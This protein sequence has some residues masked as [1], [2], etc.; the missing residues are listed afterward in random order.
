M[1]DVR[2]L[3]LDAPGLIALA[4]LGLLDAARRVMGE[5]LVPVGVMAEA[6]DGDRPGASEVSAAHA[7]RRL[8]L[9]AAIDE[10]SIGLGP[11]ESEAIAHAVVLGRPAL[12]DDM[13]ARRVARRRGVTVVGTLAVLARLHEAGELPELGGALD[14]LERIGFRM[15]P[16]L[17][18]WAIRH[19]S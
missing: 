7:S 17:R 14:E 4:R 16:D 15:T 19:E 1:A 8:T 11:G 5:L 18:A 13:Q 6:T 12:L 3:V 9:L 2:A 10:P